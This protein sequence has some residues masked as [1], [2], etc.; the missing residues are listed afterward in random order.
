MQC[1]ST[2]VKLAIRQRWLGLEL[3]TQLRAGY[4]TG[5]PHKCVCGRDELRAALAVFTP[6][7]HAVECKGAEVHQYTA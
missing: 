2:E 6:L 4:E 5:S 7:L 3:H 1:A